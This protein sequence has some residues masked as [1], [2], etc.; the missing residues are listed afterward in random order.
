MS[1][2]CHKCS[3]PIRYPTASVTCGAYC[4]LSFHTTCTGT[5]VQLLEEMAKAP[6]TFWACPLCFNLMASPRYQRIRSECFVA[7]QVSSVTQAIS[8]L[9]NDLLSE[10]RSELQSYLADSAQRKGTLGRK[11]DRSYKRPQ[12]YGRH[13]IQHY[14]L[15]PTQSSS[16][17]SQEMTQQGNS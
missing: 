14:F 4:G 13:S 1:F 5:S 10:I 6:Q 12:P 15:K 17:N 11:T 16:G 7:G 3:E 9:K 2:K 8:E